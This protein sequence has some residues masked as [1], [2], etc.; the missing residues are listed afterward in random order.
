MVF[1]DLHL[2]S[3]ASDGNLSPREV[4]G[5]AKEKGIQVISLTDHDTTQGLAEA[6]AAG[7]ELSVK[8]IPGIE[9]STETQGEEIHILG[10]YIDHGDPGLQGVLTQLKEA[11]VGRIKE[12]T[13][14]LQDLG[15]ALTWEEVREEARGASSIGRPHVAQVMVKKGYAKSIAEVFARWIGPGKPA[16]VTRYKLPTAQA[17]ELLHSAGGLAFLA[18]PGLL[19]EGIEWAEKLLSLPLDGIEVYHSEHSQAQSQEFLAWARAKNL[20]ISGGSDCHGRPH[21][22]KMGLVKIDIALLQSW[23]KD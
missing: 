13:R 11:R 19:T 9:L 18:H 7:K 2:H 8:V 1:A 12:I 21:D 23:L 20:H 10:Y 6:M 22:I 3:T 15:F 4:V 16:F 5:L 17:V 14:R